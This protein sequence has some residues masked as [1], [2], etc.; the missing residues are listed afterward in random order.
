MERG[1]DWEYEA[2]RARWT[3]IERQRRVTR[4]LVV[5][6]SLGLLALVCF[7]FAAASDACLYGRGV[8]HTCEPV[9]TGPVFALLVGGGTAALA[10]GLW[11]CH[12]AL[13]THRQYG[14]N[15]C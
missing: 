13:D 14:R 2:V 10:G 5:A 3:V 8:Q 4:R 6:F 11:L 15:G 7:L 1:E 12:S 9:T